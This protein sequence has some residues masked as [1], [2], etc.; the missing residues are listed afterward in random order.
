MSSPRSIDGSALIAGFAI[1]VPIPGLRGALFAI[2][3]GLAFRDFWLMLKA[4]G[5]GLAIDVAY[6]GFLWPFLGL[7][8]EL[9]GEYNRTLAHLLPPGA[10]AGTHH[11]CPVPNSVQFTLG[12]VGWMTLMFLIWAILWPQKTRCTMRLLPPAVG[13]FLVAIAANVLWFFAP[14]NERFGWPPEPAHKLTPVPFLALLILA[15]PLCSVGVGFV[16]A[17]LN[18]ASAQHEQGRKAESPSA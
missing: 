16:F 18:S 10:W 6:C 1:F 9:R 15:L 4:A 8:W 13:G 3:P 5:L 7:R 2:F 11:G 14:M 12:L 17:L